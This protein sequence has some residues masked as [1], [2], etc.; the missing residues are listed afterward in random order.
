MPARR[1]LAHCQ[2]PGVA[3]AYDN[4]SAIGRRSSADGPHC[5][6]P[7]R[8][9][10]QIVSH[11]RDGLPRSSGRHHRHSYAVEKAATCGGFASVFVQKIGIATSE[12]VK[13]R[14]LVFGE[15][16]QLG[17]PVKRSQALRG[18]NLTRNSRTD[19]APMRRG[20]WVGIV[21]SGLVFVFGPIGHRSL[22]LRKSE[23]ATDAEC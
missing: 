9:G 8:F 19:G 10:G 17:C 21:R 23:S 1:V 7:G 12:C 14:G 11:S 6:G 3:G 18:R 16:V 5:A 20:S 22:C 15:G 2:G 13:G 4:R